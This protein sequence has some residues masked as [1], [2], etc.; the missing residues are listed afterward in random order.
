MHSI[1]NPKLILEKGFVYPVDKNSPINADEQLQQVGIDLRLAS[2]SMVV[3]SGVLTLN[4]EATIKPTLVPLPD[5]DASFFFQAGRQYSL[6]FM[7]G[8][9]VPEDM[10]ALIIHRSTINRTIGLVLSGVYDPG[11]RSSGPSGAIFRPNVDV[12]IERG[13]RMAQVLFWSASAAN[14]YDGQYQDEGQTK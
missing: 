10:A 12:R 4:K 9:S 6:D 7:E 13:Y 2:A 1:I 3:G 14:L 5:T 8:I 11:F